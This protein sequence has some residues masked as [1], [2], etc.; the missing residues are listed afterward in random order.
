M[1]WY[2]DGA[3][4]KAGSF[5]VEAGYAEFVFEHASDYVIVLSDVEITTDVIGNKGDENAIP[6]YLMMFFGIGLVAV[7]FIAK[8]KN[9]V[10]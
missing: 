2:H 5:I 7:A 6:F 1:F 8:R 4:E 3:F 10:R 9:T